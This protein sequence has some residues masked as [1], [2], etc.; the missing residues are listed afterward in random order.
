M[1]RTLITGATGFIGCRL[2]ELWH[3]AGKE[4]LAT[5]LVRSETE[6][7]RAAGLRKAGVSMLLAD[8]ADGRKLDEA[9][10]NV[11]TVVH[12]AAAQHEANVDDE[13]FVKVNVDATREL[14]SRG[15][16]RG[17]RRIFYA[18]SIGVYGINDEATIDEDAVLAPDNAYGRSKAAAEKMIAGHPANRDDTVQVFI[19]RI[20]ETYGPWD[21]RLHK[22]YA[23]IEKGRFW[24]VGRGHNL[25]QPIYV[26]DL[27]G[28]IDR[29]LATP[30]AA[31]QP[32]ILSGDAAVT[33]REMC[34]SIAASLGRRLSRWNMPM[35]PLMLAAGGMEAT[36]GRAGIQPPLHRR[37]LDFFRKSLRFSTERRDRLLSLPPQRSFENGARKTA[38]WYREHGWL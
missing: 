37:R 1:P 9:C 35:L 22:L 30:E 20:G 33:T 15:A 11:D 18:S 32:V 36:M 25:H 8:L 4:V 7:K 34:E 16:E 17:V 2:A 6:E 24:M 38:D 27:A 14:L 10:E 13:Y 12:L 29:L 31:G 3:A 19:G 28:A 5:G 23:G 26:D 21:M